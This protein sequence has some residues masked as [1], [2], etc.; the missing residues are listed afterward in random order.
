MCFKAVYILSE[1][2][3]HTTYPL[4]HLSQG[5]GGAMVILEKILS[6]PILKKI[7]PLQQ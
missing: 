5:G 6:P 3:L 1:L 7:S 4:S 2:R